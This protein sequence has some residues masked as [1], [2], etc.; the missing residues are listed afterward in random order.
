[1]RKLLSI[2]ATFSI[3]AS[4]A[5]TLVSC[6]IKEDNSWKEVNSLPEGS[7]SIT[8][9]ATLAK[10]LSVKNNDAEKVLYNKNKNS[11]FNYINDN[12][13][14]ALA[15][16]DHL[17]K[18][19]ENKTLF[20]P[21][22]DMGIVE[23]TAE[24]LLKEKGKS[25][26]K[27]AE[28][29][30]ALEK[31]KANNINYNDLG[32]IA[33]D[34]NVITDETE[35]TLG[36]MQNA[37]DTGELVP[38]W[39]AAPAK[40][41]LGV[42]EKDADESE[43]AKW[44]NDRYRNWTGKDQNKNKWVGNEKTGNLKSENLR[45]S[46]GP[47]A[48]SFW[49]TAWQN[50]KTPEE[51]ADVLKKIAEKYETEKF[52]FYFASPYLSKSGEYYDSQRLLASAL[53]ILL[54]RDSSYDIQ[55]SLVMSTKDGVAINDGYLGVGS[56][57]TKGDIKL[58][59]DEAM[60]LYTFTKYLGMNFRLNLVTG[61]LTKQENPAT[62]WVL[63]TIQ[64]GV[65]N[66]YDNWTKMNKI[67]NGDI[68][69]G[70]STRKIKITPWI[71]RRAEKAEYFFTPEQAIAL[72]SW[73]EEKQY[74]GVGMF[75]LSRDVPSEFKSNNLVGEAMADRN[76]LDQNIRS[77]AG[78]EQFTY[79]K[80]LNGMLKSFTKQEAKTKEEV[81][82][83]GGIDYDDAIE[84]VTDLDNEQE[85]WEGPGPG[86]GAG[87]GG[88]AGENVV[89]PTGPGK[90]LYTDWESANPN[91]KS[92]ISKKDKANNETYFSPYLDA[93]L[94][95]GNDVSKIQEE[96]NL[97]HLTLAFV[98]QVNEHSDSLELS[99]AGT[100]KN[101]ESY[102]WWEETQL[103]N[104]MLKPL[105]ESKHF[106]NIKVAYGGATTG[107]FTEKNP[108]TLANILNPDDSIKAQQDLKKALIQYQQEL[109]DLAKKNGYKDVKIP[110]A[111]DF[112]IEGHAQQ[113]DQDNRLLAK[114]IAEMKKEDA[115]WDFSITLPVLPTGL[116]TIGYNV[117]NIFI[118]EFQKA[119]LAEKDLPVVNLMLM[120][121]GDPIYI[122][123]RDTQKITNFDLAKQSIEAVKGNITKSIIKNYGSVSLKESGVYNLIGATPMIG[124][125]DTVHGVFTL[126]DA[127]E[128]YN[129]SQKVELAYIGIWSMNDDRGN[130]IHTGKPI[131]KSLT[132]HGLSYLREY[133][134]AKALNGQ[135]DDGVKKPGLKNK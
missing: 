107:G 80:A 8:D 126:E 110:K 11:N 40:E 27:R 64:Q 9:E 46:F 98:Q 113:L 32:E 10:I 88:S 78:Y 133:D 65:E 62:N 33:G 132:S 49:H 122:N 99:I 89:P 84:K 5:S 129:W 36:F 61:Y 3:T 70:A 17:Q 20:T 48:N 117:M 45:I 57:H 96:T 47:F 63:D 12:Y 14:S 85:D 15:D 130:D 13:R 52:D 2:L 115:S 90:S 55:L 21:Y 108:W 127:K 16:V 41:T 86:A 42:I 123:A 59:G 43:Y 101:N 95:E 75:Y 74:G 131:N 79:A 121:Y 53:N 102:T 82:K 1:M 23:D 35:I 50:N 125:N 81:V 34:R 111:I 60:P 76:A 18:L 44:F 69:I 19:I 109:V 68:A 26:A 6:K 71:G 72:K 100:A 66:T 118:E 58:L 119:G 29:T 92:R 31:H 93:G 7:G 54:T 104:K 120:D 51:L 56:P 77:G 4:G 114:T 28:A 67:V 38:M 24:L 134:F 83:I 112:D 22:A 105:A 94:Y 103:W 25:S 91:R 87:G 97:D 30:T 37:S 39:N 135:W 106:E 116:T 128:L 73:A 124:V